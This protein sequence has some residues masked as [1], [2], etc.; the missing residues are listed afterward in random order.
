MFSW[1]TYFCV[2]QLFHFISTFQ[3]TVTHARLQI[4]RV[5]VWYT[6]EAVPLFIRDD[7]HEIDFEFFEKFLR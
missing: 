5:E 4:Y 6:S 3:T 2:F 1:K 7:F